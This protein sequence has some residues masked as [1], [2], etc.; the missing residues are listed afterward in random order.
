MNEQ[1]S[2][3]NDEHIED[4][5][6]EDFDFGENQ[7]TSMSSLQSHT[8]RGIN[9]KILGGIFFVIV[10]VI[11][12]MGYRIY[13]PSATKIAPSEIST[14][15]TSDKNYHEI[16]QAF[17]NADK[18]PTTNLQAQK[19]LF[20]PSTKSAA[21][22]PSTT[23]T[24][25]DISHVTQGLNKLNQQID[26]ILGQIKHLD[27]YSQE[28]SDNLTKLNDAIQTMDTRL[29]NLTN[30]TSTL[31]KDV[32][33]VKQVLKND[34]LDVNLSAISGQHR[35]EEKNATISIEEPEYT[36]YAVIPGR[37]WLKSTKGQ[38][39]TVAEGD[40]LGNYGKILVIDAANGVVLTSSGI[41]FR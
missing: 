32:G 3:N 12:I 30:T 36:V 11:L 20:T 34:G 37:A 5:F 4:E 41:A 27:S 33:H 17:S 28:V 14:Q 21:V 9:K 15:P 24:A 35:K 10:V 13:R 38:I 40:Q 16:S 18:V 19:E 22:K 2:P 25:S 39:I 6:N 31:S 8:K 29:S 1:K 23:S 26:Y 7:K